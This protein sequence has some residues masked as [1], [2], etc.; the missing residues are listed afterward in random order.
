M[1]FFEGFFSVETLN[2]NQSIN[3]KQLRMSRWKNS[4]QRKET[5]NIKF[6]ITSERIV[7]QEIVAEPYIDSYTLGIF[8]RSN[9]LHK[10][11]L[12]FTCAVLSFNPSTSDDVASGSVLPYDKYHLTSVF[13][14]LFLFFFGFS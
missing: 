4:L 5:K 3:G 1:R 12:I 7:V 2:M 6:C 14:C 10:Q 11:Q 8:L 9:L 13:R